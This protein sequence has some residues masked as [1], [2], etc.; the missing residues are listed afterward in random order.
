MNVNK[1]FIKYFVF[2]KMFKEY[3]I[4]FCYFVGSVGYLFLFDIL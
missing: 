3:L 4:N 2:L 1:V